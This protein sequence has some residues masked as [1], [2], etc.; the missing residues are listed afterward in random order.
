MTTFVVFSRTKSSKNVFYIGILSPK[1]SNYFVSEVIILTLL[2]FSKFYKTFTLSC[3]GLIK[4]WSL[5]LSV[6]DVLYAKRILEQLSECAECGIKSHIWYWT[7]STEYLWELCTC[8]SDLQ[9][10]IYP[11]YFQQEIVPV[12]PK[13]IS[14]GR[15]SCKCKISIKSFLSS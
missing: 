13:L 10:F 3:I 8:K 6:F 9:F 11:V 2:L 12:W 15:V 7:P 14:H 4:E 1:Y 5:M